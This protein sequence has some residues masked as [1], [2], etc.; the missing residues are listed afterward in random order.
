MFPGAGLG[1][2]GEVRNSKK[3][4]TP[5]TMKKFLLPSLFALA[6][7][8][9][10]ACASTPSTSTTTTSQETTVPAPVTTTTS[11]TKSN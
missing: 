5:S 3:Q 2:Y 6:L 8:A 1:D 9:L 4:Y 11:T 7:A 10:S